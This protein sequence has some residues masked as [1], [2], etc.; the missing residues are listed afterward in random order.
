MCPC[1]GMPAA[2]DWLQPASLEALRSHTLPVLSALDACRL[3]CTCRTLR[4][5]VFF[6][7]AADWKA[8]AQATLHQSHPAL[9]SGTL[10][11]LLAALEAHDRRQHNLEAGL[12]SVA[13]LEGARAVESVQEVLLSPCGRYLAEI[14]DSGVVVRGCYLDFAGCTS[15]LHSTPL[16]GKHGMQC[17]WSEAGDCLRGLSSS[18]GGDLGHLYEWDLSSKAPFVRDTW[19]HP[20]ARLSCYGTCISYLAYTESRF[21]VDRLLP[22]RQTQFVLHVSLS[23][24]Q[25]WH[26]PTS[27]LW[28]STKDGWLAML[29][30]ADGLSH[31]LRI[32]DL[33]A[34]TASTTLQLAAEA[35][36]GARM[37][38]SA[39]NADGRFL[40]LVGETDFEGSV[41][42]VHADN[43]QVLS[44]L[45]G[46]P[47]HNRH[48]SIEVQFSNRGWLAI[49]QFDETVDC[50]EVWSV[51]QGD[52]IFR[53]SSPCSPGP[54][55]ESMCWSHCGRLLA[56]AESF[57]RAKKHDWTIAIYG[58]D[59]QG[60]LLQAAVRDGHGEID[61]MHIVAWSLTDTT[62]LFRTVTW[63]LP[64]SG[65]SRPRWSQLQVLKLAEP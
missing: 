16:N 53:M 18:F 41:C 63:A 34:S 8:K 52:C 57:R 60:P 32:W 26:R 65:R 24:T 29:D 58:R 4:T 42:V 36:G 33:A 44:L 49:S 20:V 62:I 43:G 9:N 55:F 1:A 45:R 14:H 25:L 17:C 6:D 35:W 61:E 5:L 27:E 21:H 39:W 3:G 30:Q 2:H 51:P 12:Y 37:R 15:V 11:P 54:L 10:P 48:L 23:P 22:E 46:A 19:C 40:A 13:E 28:H 64:E 7:S 50:V 59:S 31:A 47:Q 38:L 56:V